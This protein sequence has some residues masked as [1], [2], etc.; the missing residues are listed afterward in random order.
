MNV[1]NQ[2]DRG[3]S[4]VDVPLAD[5][6]SGGFF[7]DATGSSMPPPDRPED[8]L[9]KGFTWAYRATAVGLEFVTPAIGGLILDRYAGTNPWGILGGVILGFIVGMTHLL[10]IAKQS[11]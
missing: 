9:A 5:M 11:Q 8:S 3:E 6:E 2:G 7:L 10:R 1:V 4:T